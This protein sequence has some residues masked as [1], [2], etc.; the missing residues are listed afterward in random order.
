MAISPLRK[1]LT[2]DE[3]LTS[4]NFKGFD[5]Q[6]MDRL[7]KEMDIQEPISELF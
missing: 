6:E 2:L 3:L 1:D 7:V 5:R 4:Q